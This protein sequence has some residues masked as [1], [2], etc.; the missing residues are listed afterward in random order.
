MADRCLSAGRMLVHGPALK[1]IDGAGRDNN[2]I[3]RSV[4]FPDSRAVT[5]KRR[6]LTARRGDEEGEEE[7]S[8][9]VAKAGPAP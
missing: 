1:A 8:P 7:R 5:A 2:G 3:C 6:R 9:A 4:G